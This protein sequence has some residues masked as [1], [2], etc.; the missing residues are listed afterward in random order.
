MT[1]C[2]F[3]LYTYVCF[4]FL[5]RCH[6]SCIYTYSQWMAVI[7]NQQN[8]IEYN[9]L[10]LGVE[11]AP[12]SDRKIQKTGLLIV[13]FPSSRSIAASP[14][15]HLS[16]RK[17]FAYYFIGCLFWATSLAHTHTHTRTSTQILYTVFKGPV[18]AIFFHSKSFSFHITRSACHSG[19]EIFIRMRVVGNGNL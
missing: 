9:I 6:F 1:N 18:P 16:L 8:R 17:Q 2:F 19:L 13:L 14:R 11:E 3:F 7:W 4:V 5:A 15:L 10:A 12:E